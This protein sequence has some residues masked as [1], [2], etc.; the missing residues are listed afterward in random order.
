[1]NILLVTHQLDQTGAPLALLNL[2]K[3]LKEKHNIFLASFNSGPLLEEFKRIGIS[4]FN[5]K[6]HSSDFFSLIIANTILTAPWALKFSDNPKKV[7]AWIHESKEMAI[8]SF[9]NSQK[10]SAI[11]LINAAFPAEFQINQYK[12]MNITNTFHLPNYI[13]QTHQ[14]FSPLRSLFPE[15][16]FVCV[17]P[18][19]DRKGQKELISTLSYYHLSPNIIF[20]GAK[21][22][23][24]TLPSN[25]IF[26]NQLP[27]SLSRDI[28][29]NS[30]GL[31]SF[32]KS[33]VQPLSIAESMASGIPI[34]ISDIEAHIELFNKCRAI[35]LFKTKE[36]DSFINKWGDFISQQ[37][38]N[39]IKLNLKKFS[40]EFF[41]IEN[42]SN[43][44]SKIIQKITRSY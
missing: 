28:I 33:E 20:L 22:P 41:S 1:M 12:D 35:N 3:A 7:L 36:K 21:K 24:S 42:F 2:A 34:L 25:F 9:G 39:Q 40:Q 38:D 26:T 29:H 11:S 17:G 19:S 14:T 23:T 10:L 13:D 16:Y 6:I 5:S 8:D 32:S 37:K 43:N 4:N 15:N 31:L 18:W 30:Q 44:I 27:N